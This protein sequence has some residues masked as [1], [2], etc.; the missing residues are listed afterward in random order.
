MRFESCLEN[1]SEQDRSLVDACLQVL[2]EDREIDKIA[3]LHDFSV[4]ES[5]GTPYAAIYIDSDW[6]HG[7]PVFT[8]ICFNYLDE[9]LVINRSVA[10]D[11]IGC[12]IKNH[13]ISF[14]WTGFGTRR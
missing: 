9:Y 1:I 8:G 13:N 11:I 6:E 14:N 7:L 2:F 10:N 4:G 12:V 5:V 3:I